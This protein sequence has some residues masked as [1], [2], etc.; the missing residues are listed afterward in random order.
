MNKVQV[1][2]D[3]PLNVYVSDGDGGPV[4]YERQTTADL[5]DGCM[6][7]LSI[8]LNRLSVSGGVDWRHPTTGN[9]INRPKVWWEI[10]DESFILRDGELCTCVDCLAGKHG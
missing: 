2:H 10:A 8:T 3:T 1:R 6:T 4:V 5:L 9:K 7:V